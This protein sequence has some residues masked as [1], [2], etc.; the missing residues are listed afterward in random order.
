MENYSSSS[1]NCSELFPAHRCRLHRTAAGPAWLHRAWYGL[2]AELELHRRS[3]ARARERPQNATWAEHR[4]APGRTPSPRA[5]G[6][7]SAA[8]NRA[9]WRAHPWS[10][11]WAPGTSPESWFGAPIDSLEFLPAVW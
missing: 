9:D 6:S 2:S 5:A 7:P 8:E 1:P 3:G 11:R 4:S 10:V